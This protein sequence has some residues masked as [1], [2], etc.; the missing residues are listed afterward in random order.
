[1]PG[2]IPPAFRELLENYS[3]IPKG[4]VER[5]LIEMRNIAWEI[6]PMPCLG[7]FLFL[8]LHLST[9]DELYPVVLERLLGGARLLDVGCCLGQEIRKL[10]YDGAPAEN[11]VGMDLEPRFFEVGHKL[12]KDADTKA[13]FLGA[14]V[15]K[16]NPQMEALKGSFDMLQLCMFLHMLSWDN[17]IV[18]IKNLI[19][20]LKPVKGSFF[21]G[22]SAGHVLGI[23]REAT[24][25]KLTFRHNVASFERLMREVAEDT[26]TK[27]DVRASL[28]LGS[29][30][31]NWL[32]TDNRRFLF[33]VI[34]L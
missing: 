5:H 30:R 32:D 8:E 10:I 17:Q 16:W 21:A 24:W 15:V 11:L 34:R 25:N 3:H 18:A 33:H 14:D 12:F 20:L 4:D 13:T 31:T 6:Q 9:R 22:E 1:M 7:R 19:K 26:D 27:W 2:N 23:A 28:V 29:G